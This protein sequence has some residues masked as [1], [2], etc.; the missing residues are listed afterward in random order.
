M[1]DPAL[2]ALLFHTTDL[3]YILQAV[4]LQ[5]YPVLGE[6]RA[7]SEARFRCSPLAKEGDTSFTVCFVLAYLSIISP[8]HW[9]R[10]GLARLVLD[11]VQRR[12][13]C[14]ASPLVGERSFLAE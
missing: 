1:C 3:V 13:A 7:L 2:Q 4:R 8:K 5:K 14:K 9:K 11:K 6:R 12:S 10:E